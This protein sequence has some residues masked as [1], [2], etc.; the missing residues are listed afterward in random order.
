[1]VFN[2]SRLSK[3][4]FDVW[5]YDFQ[6]LFQFVYQLVFN[7]LIF[8][9][10]I[11]IQIVYCRIIMPTCVDSPFLLCNLLC[12]S[13]P[14]EI[15]K[16]IVKITRDGCAPLFISCKR[17]N[18]EIS[19]Y[20]I[21]I[22]DADMEQKGMF[23]VP[24]DRSVHCVTPL[25]CAA[26]SGKLPVVKQLIR[27]GSCI[28]SL[29]DTGSTPVRSACYMTN[30]DIV[31]Y[32]VEHGADIKKP[33]YNGGTC[34]INSVQSVQLCMYLISKGADVNAKDIQDKTALHYAIQE[35]RLVLF[36]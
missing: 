33:N 23:E 19:E 28:N 30:M 15:R 18:V 36:S 20:L 17:G 26:V 1:M 22:C 16:E 32:L 14:R 31:H 34:L 21:T 13:S 12:F 5:L 27:L 24:V 10:L 9:P 6:G 3:F 7:N 8:V 2:S 4:C 25:W 11:H 35:H 29:S